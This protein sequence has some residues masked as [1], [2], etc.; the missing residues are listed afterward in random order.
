MGVECA[1]REPRPRDP[2]PVPQRRFCDAAG[3][4]DALRRHAIWHL[5][6]RHVRGDEDDSQRTRGEHHRHVAV[7][8]QVRQHL[9][10]TGVVE[11]G[12]MEG[13]LVHR[14]GDYR[15]HGPR[16]GQLDGAFHGLGRDT[17]GVFGEQGAGRGTVQGP[18][19]FCS[20]LPA[21][22]QGDVRV[23]RPEGERFRHHLRPDPARVA[24]G[25]GETRTGDAVRGE[26]RRTSCGAECRGSAVPRAVGPC[27]RGSD[28]SR[29]R[30]SAHL[31]AGAS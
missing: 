24:E 14:P 7:A 6:Q 26:R 21:F 31:R 16:P 25:D 8:R 2:P 9:S 12:E 23:E 13:M 20:P 28:P 22:Q 11:S 17:T 19:G 1:H 15:I 18:G 10:E 30:R 27:S 3:A 4:D 29:R 5:P